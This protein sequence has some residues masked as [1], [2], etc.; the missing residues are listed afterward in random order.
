MNIISLLKINSPE[1]QAAEIGA[2]VSIAAAFISVIMAVYNRKSDIREHKRQ[3]L[4][5]LYVN[6]SKELYTNI[7]KLA[8]DLGNLNRMLLNTNLNKESL[9]SHKLVKGKDLANDP[10][11]NI[12]NHNFPSSYYEILALSSYYPFL[13]SITNELTRSLEELQET[14]HD[15]SSSDLTIND[16]CNNNKNIF[17][18]IGKADVNLVNMKSLLQRKITGKVLEMDKNSKSKMSILLDWLKK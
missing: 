12:F 4:L 15:L 11:L 9:S 7:D 1:V 13:I 6:N 10:I 14:L 5:E 8:N 2:V 16:F 18:E 3:Y 17:I